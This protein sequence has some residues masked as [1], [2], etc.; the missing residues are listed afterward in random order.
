MDNLQSQE[1]S[2][3]CSV[4]QYAAVAALNGPQDCVETMRQEFAR[5]R[6]YTLG[7][8]RALPGINLPDPGGAFYAFFNVSPYF[9]KPLGKGTDREELDRFLHGAA[10]GGA[11]WR[12]SRAMRLGP[13]LRAAV[14]RDSPR[15]ARGGL[16]PPG[17]CFCA[18]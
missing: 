17:R 12:S 2:N 13:G 4:S 3:P 11:T 9:G 15:N 10:G 5:R 18:R 14:V 6:T 1:T 7:R 8:I 16:Q